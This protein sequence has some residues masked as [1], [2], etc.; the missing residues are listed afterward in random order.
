MSNQTKNSSWG[1]NIVGHI[2]GEFG[3]G[4]S[5]RSNIRVIETANIPFSLRNIEVGWHRNLDH[6]YADY[7][8]NQN[9]YSINLITINPEGDIHKWIGNDF[10]KNRYNIDHWNR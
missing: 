9:A 7:L 2:T 6:T 5:V 3:L 1:I 4:E 10:Y 8:S